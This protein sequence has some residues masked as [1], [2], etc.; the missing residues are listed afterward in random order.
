MGGGSDRVSFFSDIGDSFVNVFTRPGK[1]NFGDF[2]KVFTLGVGTPFV[3][4]T[5]AAPFAAL[6]VPFVPSAPVAAPAAASTVLTAPGLDLAVPGITSAAGVTPTVG[7][8]V[9]ASSADTA[10]AALTAKVAGAGAAKVG[11]W[12]TVTSGAKDFGGFV[13]GAAEVSLA[14]RTLASPWIKTAGQIRDAVSGGSAITSH[15]VP[16]AAG[17]GNFSAGSSSPAAPRSSS[18]VMPVVVFAAA[19]LAIGYYIVT[20]LLPGGRHA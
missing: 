13:K 6:A 15:A 7:G 19:A 11:F 1:A 5:I 12:E 16:V 3:N 9:G 20:E 2:A 18:A 17:G 14:A 4:S 10:A 8:V